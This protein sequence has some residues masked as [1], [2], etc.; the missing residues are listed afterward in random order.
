MQ[1]IYEKSV[2]GRRAITLDPLDVPDASLPRELCREKSAELPEVARRSTSFVIS[3]ICR[4]ATS[5]W[6]R[7]SIRSVLAR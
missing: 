3:R 5:A 6:I 7:I 4:A 1:L 2:Q